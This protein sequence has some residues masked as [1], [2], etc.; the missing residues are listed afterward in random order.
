MK[1]LLMQRENV[2]NVLSGE[3]L[4]RRFAQSAPSHSIDIVP[5]VGALAIARTIA[6]IDDLRSRHGFAR[7]AKLSCGSIRK[8]SSTIAA[9]NVSI[10]QG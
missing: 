8:R 2:G 6:P 7:I 4:L 1:L 3:S 10:V 9:F 5:H